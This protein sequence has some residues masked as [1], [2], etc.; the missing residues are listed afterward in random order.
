MKLPAVSTLK[1]RLASVSMASS[2]VVSVV[3]S[4]E[5]T[6]VSCR[7]PAVSIKAFDEPTVKS[8]P[9]IVRSPEKDSSAAVLKCCCG[10]FG[11]NRHLLDIFLWWRLSLR[12]QRLRQLELLFR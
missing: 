10:H 1:E 4:S 6:L 7:E 12:L 5:S 11:E 9:V 2:M 3:E 8:P